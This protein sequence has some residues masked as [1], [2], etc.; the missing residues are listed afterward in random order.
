MPRLLRLSP[1]ECEVISLHQ[2]SYSLS[3]NPQK[4]GSLALRRDSASLDKIAEPDGSVAC[5]NIPSRMLLLNGWHDYSW[6][7]TFRIPMILIVKT[8]FGP[9]F[10]DLRL[11]CSTRP[12]IHRNVQTETVSG[13]KNEFAITRQKVT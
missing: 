6:E 3:A 5:A 2:L 10:F 7:G 9:A 4:S 12:L 1:S 11:S 13:R 8:N